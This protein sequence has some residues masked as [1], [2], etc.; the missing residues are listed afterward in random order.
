MAHRRPVRTIFVRTRDLIAPALNGRRIMRRII[1]LAAILVVLAVVVG[2]LAEQAVRALPPAPPTPLPAA[3]LAVA[4]PAPV[5]QNSYGG[6]VVVPR[7]ARGH[8][9][10]DARVD[11]RRMNFMLDTGASVVALRARDAAALGIHPAARDFTVLVKTANGA[12]RAAPVQLGMVE[13]GG[14]SLRNVVAVVSPDEVLSENL[15]GLSFLSRLRR[16]EYSNGR[17]VLEQ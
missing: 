16:Y 10:V 8:F 3:A 2:Q 15:L 5:E 6:S 9:V 13:I 11:G 14:L 1:T 12:T 4:P 7:D 17:M